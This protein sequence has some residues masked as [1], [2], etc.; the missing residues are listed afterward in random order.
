MVREVSFDVFSRWGEIVYHRQDFLPN[1]PAYAWDGT[2]NGEKLDPGVFIC[3]V[4]IEF[5]DGSRSVLAGDVLV[6]H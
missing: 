5:L 1:D 6:I 2:F 4:E 3:Q